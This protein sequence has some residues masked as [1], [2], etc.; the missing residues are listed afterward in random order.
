MQPAKIALI[1]CALTAWFVTACRSTPISAPIGAPGAPESEQ[2]KVASPSEASKQ[3][4]TEANAAPALRQEALARLLPE[5]HIGAPEK[6]LASRRLEYNTMIGSRSLAARRKAAWQ[7]R[8]TRQGQ[9]VGFEFSNYGGNRI[10]PPRRDAPKNQFYTRDFQFRFDGRARQDIHLM[11]SDWVPSRDRVFRLSEIMNSLMLF[12]P[13]T[14]LPAIVNF[15]ERNIVT[16]PTGEEVEFDAETH[17]IRGGVFSEAPVDLNPDRTARKFPSVEYRGAGVTVRVNSRGSDPR[18][19]NTATV[20][21][22]ASS[23]NCDKGLLCNQCLV[24]SKELWDQSG[25]ARFK[26]STDGELDRFLVARC[27][28]GLPKISPGVVVTTAVQ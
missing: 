15:G 10:L 5:S 16:L 8:T 21:T 23:P 18:I 17:E 9:I 1:L 24:P 4:E 12:F 20:S 22:G 6:D 25:A 28:F 3:S 7:Y 14:W 13:R 26:F 11:V 19:G 27:G 2:P